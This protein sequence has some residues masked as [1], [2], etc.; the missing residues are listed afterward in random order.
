[1]K[2]IESKKKN[3]TLETILEKVESMFGDVNV[4][5][6]SIGSKLKEHDL[7]FEKIDKQF[8]KVDERFN[9]LEIT[10]KKDID[11]LAIA[12]AR[13]FNSHKFPERQ[14]A[15]WSESERSENFAKAKFSSDT[16]SR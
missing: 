4:K 2:K 3:I 13:G 9:K 1:M 6:T 15:G 14:L 7:R 11:D 16:P 12:T 5:L 10:L 8:E